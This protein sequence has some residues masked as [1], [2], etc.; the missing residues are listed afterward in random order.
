MGIVI[1]GSGLA[2]SLKEKA[3]INSIRLRGNL[4]A[5]GSMAIC[6]VGE[7]LV[8]KMDRSMREIFTKTTVMER[9][10]SNI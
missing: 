5:F 8:M 1:R 4:R 10:E 3:L 7:G 6:R 2:I 9:G